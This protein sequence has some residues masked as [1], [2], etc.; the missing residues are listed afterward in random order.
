MNTTVEG[1]AGT[2]FCALRDGFVRAAARGEHVMTFTISN[3]CPD[4]R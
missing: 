2:V 1:D 3:G 4:G